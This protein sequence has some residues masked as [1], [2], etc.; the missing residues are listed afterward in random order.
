MD[1]AEILAIANGALQ[2]LQVLGPQLA[3]LENTGSVSDDL[4]AQVKAT[5]DA[6]RALSSGPE[7]KTSTGK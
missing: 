1:P 6:F 2:I 3:A 4:Q 5:N 7:W